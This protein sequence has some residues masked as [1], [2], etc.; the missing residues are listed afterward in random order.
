MIGITPANEVHVT[1][2]ELLTNKNQ[3]IVGEIPDNEAQV[4]VGEPL[5]DGSQELS[6]KYFTKD[7]KRLV[8]G[9]IFDR[10][11]KKRGLRFSFPVLEPSQIL[12]VKVNLMYGLRTQYRRLRNACYNAFCQKNVLFFHFFRF[13]M[14]ISKCFSL[15]I[16]K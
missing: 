9:H 12:P 4:I 1:F 8:T 13:E 6:A 7:P 5:T 2:G 15:S 11:S 10:F 14:E 16:R 3:E